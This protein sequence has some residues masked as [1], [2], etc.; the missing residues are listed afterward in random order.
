MLPDG[1][2]TSGKLMQSPNKCLKNNAYFLLSVPLDI[3]DETN[4]LLV[5]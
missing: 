1:C 3:D 5:R 4:F 2:S